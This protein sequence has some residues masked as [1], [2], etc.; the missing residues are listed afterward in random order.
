V[1]GRRISPVAAIGHPPC[2]GPRPPP[3]AT[4]ATVEIRCLGWLGTRTERAEELAEFYTQVLGLPLVHHEAGFWVFA[5]PDGHHVEVF[6]PAYPG[7]DHFTTGPVVGFGVGDLA[8]A[9]V[10]L[11]RAGVA[12]VGEAGPTWQHFR[13]P[14]GNLYE[15]VA[16][17]P[18]PGLEAA[19]GSALERGLAL[20]EEGRLLSAR[21]ELQRATEEDPRDAEAWYWLAV[22][23]D[24]LGMEGSAIPSY[25]RALALGC[26][27]RAGAHAYLA[28]SL[29]KT[30]RA[31]EALAESERAR[32][33]RPHDPLVA[34]IHANVLAD[35]GQHSEAEAHYREALALDP[36][37]A[38]AWHGLGQ[39]LAYLGRLD[40][41]REAYDLAYE[42]GLDPGQS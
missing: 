33:L 3:G 12:L 2:A 5:L 11:R 35:L 15:L 28:S 18:A 23:E 21:R 7:K 25:R 24:N 14:D 19:H 6:S 42:R 41:A 8:S 30:W 38:P 29:Q 20:R 13:A 27:D 36:A 39:L 22:T 40:E 34:F 4:F 9:V 1:G 31:T 32:Q 37:F 10:E 17:P 26:T 16:D